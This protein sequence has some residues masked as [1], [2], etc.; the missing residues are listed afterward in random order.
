MKDEQNKCP[1]HEVD[2]EATPVHAPRE[3]FG[4]GDAADQPRDRKAVVDGTEEASKR[5]EPGEQGNGNPPMMANPTNRVVFMPEMC[6]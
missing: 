2:R 3:D 5:D 1:D 4:G 6:Q